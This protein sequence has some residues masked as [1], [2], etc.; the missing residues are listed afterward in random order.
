MFFIVSFRGIE[1]YKVSVIMPVYNGEKDIGKSVDSI[2]NQTLNFNN[3]ELII[4]DDKST[5]NSLKIIKDY[6]NK[7]N[8]IKGIFLEK[9]TGNP[10]KPRNIG[11]KNSTSD[12]LMFI[13]CGD[14]YNY[15]YCEVMYNEMIN[16]NSLDLVKCSHKSYHDGTVDEI[17]LP[18]ESNHPFNPGDDINVFHDG[19]IWNGIFKKDIIENNNINF[20]NSGYEDTFFSYQYYCNSKK[21]LYLSDYFGCNYIIPD[22]S[23]DDASLSRGSSLKKI[24]NLYEGNKI[25][26]EYLGENTNN[27]VVNLSINKFLTAIFPLLFKLNKKEDHYYILNE[28]YN[29]ET[30]ASSKY[31]FSFNGNHFFENLYNRLL[32]SEHFYWCYF[33]GKT[34]SKL[35]NSNFIRKWYRQYNRP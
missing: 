27:E 6:M 34:L 1:M 5:D 31:D 29:F 11:I 33:I 26:T 21:V 28:F 14:I 15:D 23:K 19:Y 10:G 20:I 3:I 25:I 32:L 4:V 8:N 30:Y 12:Y 22:I 18:M 9:N 17:R 7:Y 13:D 2:I 24:L 35:Y 16:D